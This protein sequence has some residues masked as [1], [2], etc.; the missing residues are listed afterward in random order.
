M[1]NVDEQENDFETEKGNDEQD[2][3]NIHNNNNKRQ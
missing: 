2:K 3:T 1:S